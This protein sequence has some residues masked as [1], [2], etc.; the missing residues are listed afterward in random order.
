MKSG[1]T[2]TDLKSPE[3]LEFEVA[4]ILAKRKKRLGS[5]WRGRE[6]KWRKEKAVRE[7]MEG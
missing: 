1:T 7:E 3:K 2:H 4:R 5:M 6:G